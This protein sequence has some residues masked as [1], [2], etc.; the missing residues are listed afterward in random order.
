[1]LKRHSWRKPKISSLRGRA[2]YPDKI[3]L[4]DVI[5]SSLVFKDVLPKIGML[6]GDTVRKVLDAYIVLGQYYDGL[7]RAYGEP[8]EFSK[9]TRAVYMRR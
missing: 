4:P 5:Q 6:E 1:M 2:E 9:Q 3:L 7:L 8:Y